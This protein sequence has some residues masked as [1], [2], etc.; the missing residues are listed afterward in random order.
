MSI[1]KKKDTA[2]RKH[3]EDT[4]RA[5]R[6]KI[7]AEPKPEKKYGLVELSQRWGIADLNDVKRIADGKCREFVGYDFFSRS[8]LSWATEPPKLIS[9]ITYHESAVLAYEDKQKQAVVNKGIA[10]D[11]QSL[12]DADAK[13]EEEAAKRAARKGKKKAKK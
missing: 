5:I 9:D 6:E 8:L 13:R 10:A 11:I 3:E 7:L 4:L 1:F 12:K 2:A